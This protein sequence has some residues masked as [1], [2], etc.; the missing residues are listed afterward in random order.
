MIDAETMR[1]IIKSRWHLLLV[2]LTGFFSVLAISFLFVYL[3]SKV[4]LFSQHIYTFSGQDRS[5]LINSDGTGCVVFGELQ[6]CWGRSFLPGGKGGVK[7]NSPF[8]SNDYVL[9]LT[10]VEEVDEDE[11]RKNLSAIVRQKMLDG[12]SVVVSDDQTHLYA[13]HVDYIAIGKVKVET[14]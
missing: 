1:E 2:L 12:A 8:T 14:Q 5:N 13:T 4:G 3:L 11:A 7:F 10:P 9:T 6:T